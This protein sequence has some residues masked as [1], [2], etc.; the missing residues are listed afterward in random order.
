MAFQ[1]IEAPVD[2]QDALAREM[3]RMGLPEH[4]IIA[5]SADVA[6]KRRHWLAAGARYFRDADH[7]VFIADAHALNC[8]PADSPPMWW[9]R[10]YRHDGQPL[11]NHWRELQAI[12]NELIGPEHQGVEFYPP[13]RELRDGENSYHLFVFK[14]PADRLA[15]G[16]PG[17]RNRGADGQPTTP[18][19][20]VIDRVAA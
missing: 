14:D 12:K 7:L 20:F 19:R 16:L 3:Q 18:T 17:Q 1:R 15:F 5:G 8:A 2:D 4:E 6:S 10:V 9:M 11:V 13:E